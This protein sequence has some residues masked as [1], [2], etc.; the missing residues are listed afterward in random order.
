MIPRQP[1]DNCKE[2]FK[3]ANISSEQYIC[4]GEENSVDTCS[5]DSGGPLFWINKLKNSGARH[6]QH[7]IVAIGASGCGRQINQNTPPAFYTNLAHYIDWIR[8]NVI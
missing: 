7:G 3:V 2:V 8:A 6:V 5:G 4:A 1:V